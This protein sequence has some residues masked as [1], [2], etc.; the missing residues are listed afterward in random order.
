MKTRPLCSSFIQFL[1]YMILFKTHIRSE[2]LGNI[3][4][5]GMGNFKFYIFLF[6]NISKYKY[7]H[8]EWINIY[9]V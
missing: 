2:W 7:K 9:E 4:Y 8:A 3:V 1:W 6:V 5:M